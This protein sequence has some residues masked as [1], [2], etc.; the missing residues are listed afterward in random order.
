MSKKKWPWIAVDVSDVLCEENLYLLLRQCE[1]GVP[2][3]EF[4]YDNEFDAQAEA[5]KRNAEEEQGEKGKMDKNEALKIMEGLKTIQ[6]HCA[7]F[8]HCG[9]CEFNDD[10]GCILG[11]LGKTPDRYWNLDEVED[12]LM[13]SIEAVGTPDSLWEGE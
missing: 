9:E 5:A 1:N 6:K 7:K 12:K 8:K 11:Q 4:L 13:K 3:I 2:G 10:T